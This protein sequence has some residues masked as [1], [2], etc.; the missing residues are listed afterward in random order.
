M[1]NKVKGQADHGGQGLMELVVSVGVI[2]MVLAGTVSL[3]IFSMG[4][5]NKSFDRSKATRLAELVIERLVDTKGDEPGTFWDLSQMNVSDQT[6]TGFEDYTYSVDFTD[7]SASC[8]CTNCC[9][10]AVVSVKWNGTEQE[11]QFSRFFAK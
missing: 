7:L 3:I 10:K 9:A 6:L 11:L 8:S 2:M 1:K 4:K 5:R